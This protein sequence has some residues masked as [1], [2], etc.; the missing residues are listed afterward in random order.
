MYVVFAS[1]PFTEIIF[2]CP[3]V[4]KDFQSPVEDLKWT[5]YLW[6]VPFPSE[7]SSHRRV[8]PEALIAVAKGFPGLP[9]GSNSIGWPPSYK[10][11][12]RTPSPVPFWTF[13]TM[14]FVRSSCSFSRTK[15]LKFLALAFPSLTVSGFSYHDCVERCS[16]VQLPVRRNAYICSTSASSYPTVI[17]EKQ[18]TWSYSKELITLSRSCRVVTSWIPLKNSRYMDNSFISFFIPLIHD[19][20]RSWW[21]GEDATMLRASVSTCSSSSPPR[22]TGN[23]SEIV[24]RMFFLY[25]E[26]AFPHLVIRCLIVGKVEHVLSS[27]RPHKLVSN[28]LKFAK[29]F[30]KASVTWGLT[31]RTRRTSCGFKVLNGWSQTLLGTSYT[32]LSSFFLSS[33]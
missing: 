5:M 11:T 7:D 4:G 14:N 33:L 15:S 28:S 29:T 17:R 10:R 23:I 18:T 13:E 2:S 6:T 22:T 24:L 26:T 3:T 16:G 32:W 30:C 20:R 25:L 19:E 27:T 31:S 9:G 21:N 8:I 12:L 1:N